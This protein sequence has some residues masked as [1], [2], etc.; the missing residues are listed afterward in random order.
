MS[1]KKEGELFNLKADEFPDNSRLTAR[2]SDYRCMMDSMVSARSKF[3][4]CNSKYVQKFAMPTVVLND[5]MSSPFGLGQ[6][7][8]FLLNPSFRKCKITEHPTTT[9][10]PRNCL[11]TV[12]C[13]GGQKKQLRVK[14]HAPTICRRKGELTTHTMAPSRGRV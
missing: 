11:C 3:L 1:L 14:R 6:V 10:F 5:S 13:R 2:L 9:F 4:T 12:K 7:E 8:H